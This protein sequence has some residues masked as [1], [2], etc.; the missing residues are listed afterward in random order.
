ATRA[1]AEATLTNAEAMPDNA[2]RTL[3]IQHKLEFTELAFISFYA[4]QFTRPIVEAL[5][6]AKG[7]APLI[8]AWI[9]EA[10]FSIARPY[11]P[12]A[13]RCGGFAWRGRAAIADR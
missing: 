1:N 3:D 6:D 4:L 10:T 5:T 8:A 2:T 11:I 12:D 9:P 7:S 13:D